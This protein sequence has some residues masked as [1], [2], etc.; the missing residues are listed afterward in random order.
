MD[1]GERKDGISRRKMLKRIGTGAAITWSAPVLTSIRTPAFAQSP[2]PETCP[3]FGCPG[4]R[5][6]PC[7]ENPGGCTTGLC[8][9][10]IGE[11]YS[12]FQGEDTEGGCHCYQNMF[13]S[14][15]NPCYSSFDC[16]PRQFC[17]E[18][19][20]CGPGG[21]CLNCCGEGC[22]DPSG[23]SRPRGATARR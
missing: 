2:P 4:E 12:C 7:T 20:G 22:R 11:P 23:R 21:I 18:D 1:P 9:P 13:C 17:M 19:T 16:G 3:E 8:T 15:L 10:P 6:Q 5:F 14:C